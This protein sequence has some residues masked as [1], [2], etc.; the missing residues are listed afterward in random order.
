MVGK[1]SNLQLLSSGKWTDNGPGRGA[2]CSNSLPLFHPPPASSRTLVTTL[3]IRGIK[4]SFLKINFYRS[5]CFTAV[6]FCC[7]AKW[8]GCMF[9]YVP[10]LGFPSCLGR[11]RAPSEVSCAMQWV[12]M[13]YFTHT[14]HSGYMSILIS[15]FIPS[16]FINHV[17]KS[18]HIFKARSISKQTPRNRVVWYFK[19][20]FARHKAF[21]LKIIY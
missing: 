6:S 7:A 16:P 15:Q 8:I 4:M 13:S 12:L 14:I 1:F 18:T 3:E 11:H 10:F 2:V 20:D 17:F 5:S 19:K 9:T 21:N